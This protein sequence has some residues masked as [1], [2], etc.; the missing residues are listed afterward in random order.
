MRRILAILAYIFIGA[1]ILAM[2]LLFVRLM[3]VTPADTGA[4]LAGDTG[5]GNS[6][7]FITTSSA[8]PTPPLAEIIV[9]REQVNI[10]GGEWDYAIQ[11]DTYSGWCD[12][13]WCYIGQGRRIWQGC[14]NWA[15]QADYEV[16]Q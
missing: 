6:E 1:V 11:G 4:V 2:P 12:G 8:A 13:T 9:T 10:H 16:C 15:S 5:G 7:Q 3:E 14:T